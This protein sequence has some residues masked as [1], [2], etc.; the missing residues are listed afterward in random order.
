MKKLLV[1]VLGLVMMIGCSSKKPDEVYLESTVKTDFTEKEDALFKDLIEWTNDKL[2]LSLSSKFIYKDDEKNYYSLN[3]RNNEE[4]VS[5]LTEIDVE[6]A[7]PYMVTIMLDYDKL[8]EVI[9]VVPVGLL[10]LNIDGDINTTSYNIVE[11]I[12]NSLEEKSDGMS[13]FEESDVEVTFF[14][15]KNQNT[16]MIILE[17]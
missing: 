13:T 11:G 14:G 17:K 7:K 6:N 9:N 15:S 3:Y 12:I 8:E 16:Y 5:Y 1:V 4:Y 10:L 2:D